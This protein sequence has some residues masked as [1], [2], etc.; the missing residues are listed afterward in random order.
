[1]YCPKCHAEFR[2]GFTECS[3]CR[4]P[5]VWELPPELEGPG[6]PHL[7]WVSVLEGD[8]PLIIGSAKELLD[9]AGIPFYI[10]GDEFGVRHTVID[11]HIHR[12]CRICV[13]RDREAQARAILEQFAED[14]D[15]ASDR[16]E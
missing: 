4:V 1:V 6:D 10:V 7:E 16:P 2:P 11:G 5:L 13:G 3:D 15:S 12:W 8:D 9:R 14:I